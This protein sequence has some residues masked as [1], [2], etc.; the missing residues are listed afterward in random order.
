MLMTKQKILN[1]ISYTPHN[2]NFNILSQMLD[3]LLETKSVS[4][5]EELKNALIKGGDVCLLNDIQIN[6]EIILNKDTNLDLNGKKIEAE[7]SYGGWYLLKADNANLV[8]SGNGLVSAGKSVQAIPVTSTNNA[9]VKILD[10]EFACRGQNQ[11]VYSN[12][13]KVEIYGGI[14]RVVEGDET[15]DLLNVQNTKKVEDIRVYGGKFI[16]RDPQLGDDNLGGSFVAEGYK[17]IEVEPGVFEVK[18][19]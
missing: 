11:C 5:Q 18:N 17:S 13:G 1:Y 19:N 2:T 15:K 3:E 10:G 12:G 16:G 14:Y 9:I 6:S 7:S 8:I 4:T